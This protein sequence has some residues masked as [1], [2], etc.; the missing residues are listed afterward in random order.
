MNNIWRIFVRDVRNVCT[1]VIGVIVVIGLIVVPSLYAWFNIAASWDPY[2]NT[3]ELKVAVAS[4]DQGYKSDLVP[5][6]INVGETVISTLRAN[7]QLDWQ[8][9]KSDQAVDGVKSGE[10]YAAIVIPK[11]FSADMMTLFSTNVK[12]AELMYYTNEKANA[13]APHITDEGASTITN[14]IDSTFAKTVGQVELDLVSTLFTYMQSDQMKQYVSVAT[15]NLSAM[16]RQLRSAAEQTDSY[17]GL[18]KASQN[19]IAS[20]D[21]LIASSG[22]NV[23]SAKNSLRQAKSGINSL[24]MALSGAADSIDDVLAQSGDS[25]DAVSKQVD[26]SFS[27]IGKQSTAAQNQL[28]QLSSGVQGVAVQYDAL[29]AQLQALQKAV[30]SSGAGSTNQSNQ[31]GQ[32][33]QDALQRSIDAMTRA[34][35]RQRQLSKDLSAA[36]KTLSNTDATTQK[37]R[38][39]LKRQ[40]TQAKSSITSAKNT[41][42]TGLKPKLTALGNTIDDVN[43]QSSSVARQLGNTVDSLSGV[44]SGATDSVKQI[45][46]ILDDSSEHLRDSA[47]KVDTLSGHLKTFYNNGDPAQ[48]KRFASSDVDKLATLLSSPVSVNRIAVYHMDNYGSAMAPFYTILAIWVGAIVLVAMMKV[49]LSKRGREEL[50]GRQAGAV[51]VASG[52]ASSRGK[53]KPGDKRHRYR[54]NLLGR[55]RSHHPL[56]LYEEYFGRYLFFLV[57]ALCQAGLVGLGDL[58]YLGI[59]HVSAFKFLLVCWVS[60]IVFSNI[61]YTLTLSF[62]DIG[63]AVAVVLLV[64]QVAG[65]GGTFPVEMLPAPFQTLYPFLPFPHG[66]AAM[67]AAMAGAYG[68]EYWVELGKLALF[69]VPSLLLG[70]VLRKPVIRLNNWVIRNLESTKLM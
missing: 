26:A 46:G 60:A 38:S 16:S 7:D 64:M 10:Y 17:S 14:Q 9:V 47:D 24:N 66:I 53:A 49:S 31:A 28:K 48:L 2:G 1:N 12:H 21:S 51:A 36:A 63:K 20:T 65:S 58:Y 25:Y 55:M 27:N 35:D 5:V 4:D 15:T 6:K 3:S 43:T 44:S 52:I 69:I 68:N 34:R 37:K 18:L 62:G 39:E 56:R 41:Y 45:R 61:T 40:I 33:V 8:F 67:H 42:R 54:G 23:D 30:G 29:I 32:T 70:L 50:A 19:I 57:L 13:I 11:T 22:G 59:Q